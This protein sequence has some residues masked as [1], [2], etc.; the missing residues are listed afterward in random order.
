[1]YTDEDTHTQTH[2]HTHTHTHIY[3]LTQNTHIYIPAIAQK[4][5]PKWLRNICKI[6]ECVFNNFGK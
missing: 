4:K 1:M 2:R 3:I 5:L 6:K